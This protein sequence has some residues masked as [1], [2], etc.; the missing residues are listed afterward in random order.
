MA[1]E[2]RLSTRSSTESEVSQN[3]N[4]E[5]VGVEQ[6]RGIL[7]GSSPSLTPPACTLSQ[8]NKA[9]ITPTTT[10]KHTTRIMV[11]VVG[12]G[13]MVVN[14]IAADKLDKLWYSVKFETL[15]ATFINGCFFG[16]L[17]S[18]WSIQSLLLAARQCPH[19]HHRCRNHKENVEIVYIQLKVVKKE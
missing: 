18:I 16:F 7:I 6:A 12:L 14:K 10:A 15:H 9:T 17:G 11:V 2:M 3:G 5:V 4:L 13:K 19:H 1:Y 8:P